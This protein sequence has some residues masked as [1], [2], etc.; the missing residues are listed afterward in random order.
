MVREEEEEGVGAEARSE[1]VRGSLLLL[2]SESHCSSVFSSGSESDL[3]REKNLLELC[4]EGSFSSRVVSDRGGD[5]RLEPPMPRR[6]PRELCVRREPR[7][8]DGNPGT[9]CACSRASVC[10]G[11]K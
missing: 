8:R 5:V 3:D 11:A 4:V 10:S 2:S 6:R 7:P 9:G 1:V